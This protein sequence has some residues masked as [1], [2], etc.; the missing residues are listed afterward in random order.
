LELFGEGKRWFDLVRT[1]NV[2][3]V[4]DD[5]INRRLTDLQGGIP[6]TE[7][8]GSDMGRVLWPIFRTLLE[9]NKKL[10][11]NPSYR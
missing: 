10:V 6:F 1:N 11:Q 5:V 7:G 2:N 4:M 8:F 3:R 9:D